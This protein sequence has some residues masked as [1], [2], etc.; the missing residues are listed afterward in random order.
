MESPLW[1]GVCYYKLHAL[2]FEYLIWSMDKRFYFI[3]KHF[4]V[5]NISLLRTFSYIIANRNRYGGLQV[6]KTHYVRAQ[7]FNVAFQSTIS[8]TTFSTD[9]GTLQLALWIWNAEFL[10]RNVWRS[11][12]WF[13]QRR[14]LQQLLLWLQSMQYDHLS[15]IP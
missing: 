6:N 3:W 14:N 12:L 8:T 5:Y 9:P 15:K 1:W 2:L 7:T 10:F 4:K 13:R 11:R